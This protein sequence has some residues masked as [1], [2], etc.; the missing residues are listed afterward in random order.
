MQMPPPQNRSPTLHHGT[1]LRCN[2]VLQWAMMLRRGPSLQRSLT[3][4]RGP[5]ASWT[6][7]RHGLGAPARKLRATL[8]RGMRSVVASLHGGSPLWIEEGRCS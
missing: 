2:P 8:R 1:T 4:R 3:L 5:V 7:A 6:R